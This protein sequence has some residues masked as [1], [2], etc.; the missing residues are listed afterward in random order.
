MNVLERA[1]RRLY[2]GGR[3]SRLARVL[4]RVSGTLHAAGIRPHRLV[5][6]QVHGRRTGRVI[7]FPLVMVEID[8]SRY[9]VSMLGEK[10]NWVLNIRAAQGRAV[11][12]HG[13]HEDV[14]LEDVPTETRPPILRRY[15]E[16]A[17][18]ARPHLPIDQ[19]ASLDE[20]ARVA[21]AVPVFR[22]MTCA[23]IRPAS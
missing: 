13:H 11:L 9:L 22:V 3:P 4:N 20:I 6:L 10:A 19:H 2:A 16:N 5:T 14:R 23:P 1:Q 21:D 15:L 18:G 8:G 7:S 17:P 12:V